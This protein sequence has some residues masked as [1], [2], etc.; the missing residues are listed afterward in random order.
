MQEFSRGNM[1]NTLPKA[2]VLHLVKVEVEAGN[3]YYWCACGLS[4]TQPFCD[5]SH[6]GS[7][8]APMPYVATEDR[9][10]SFCGC[11]HS[12]QAPF[13]DGTHKALREQNS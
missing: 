5:G 3:T 8:F 4:H 10:V 1:P 11:K 7:G 2:A 13:C 12:A 6:R 9:L